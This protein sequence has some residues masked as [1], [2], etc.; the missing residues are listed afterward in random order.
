MFGLFQVIL[1]FGV[2][3][4]CRS[5]EMT[6]LTVN[7]VETHNNKMIIHLRCTKNKKDR[8]FV[9]QDELLKVV[10]KYQKLRPAD[11]KTER[12]F[13]NFKNG[14]CTKQAVGRH[15]IA[16]IPKQ[17]ATYL[18]LPDAESYTGHCLRRSSVTLLADTGANLTTL[19]RHGGW[20]SDKVAEGYIEES[21][22]N[23]S[24]IT[25]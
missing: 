1:I 12:F 2:N 3:G 5:N 10:Q 23:K 17:I 14:K 8:M 13:I 6:T 25:T 7:N 4:A 11:T 22:K 20:K 9:V 16:R 24:K 15:K 18:N 19:K 21:I